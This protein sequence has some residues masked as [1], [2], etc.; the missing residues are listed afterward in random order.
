[1]VAA[2]GLV[3]DSL[4][5]GGW[6]KAGSGEVSIVDIELLQLYILHN[7]I[8]KVPVVVYRVHATGQEPFLVRAQPASM[9]W[10]G[11]EDEA[12]GA[13]RTALLEANGQLIGKLN[14]RCPRH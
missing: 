11:S 10:S 3:R 2:A 5:A 1:L 8:T 6:E 12:I 9:V 7:H 4:Q 14:A 13:Y